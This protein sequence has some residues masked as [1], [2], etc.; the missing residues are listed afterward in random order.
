M[1]AGLSLWRRDCSADARGEKYR[2]LGRYLLA[3]SAINQLDQTQ[4]QPDDF[5]VTDDGAHVM[6]YLGASD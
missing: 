3:A 4:L 5:A 1:P 6:I 2:Q